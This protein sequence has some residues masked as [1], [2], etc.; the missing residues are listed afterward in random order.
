[1]MLSDTI[2]LKYCLNLG[3]MKTSLDMF[4]IFS[5]L[6]SIYSDM[7]KMLYSCVMI[8]CT[9]IVHNSYYI[10]IIRVHANLLNMLWCAVFVSLSDTSMAVSIAEVTSLKLK[11]KRHH[12][13][14]HL[15]CCVS[16]CTERQ[17]RKSR[18]NTQRRIKDVCW[19]VSFTD[20]LKHI[21]GKVRVRC[22]NRL[23]IRTLKTE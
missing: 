14:T 15:R 3:Q 6:W 19:R 11:N 7:M 23:H 13:L 18:R 17:H 12:H 5:A 2:S 10:C 16:C 22:T 20:L 4:N 1:M 21:E 9:V 8:S